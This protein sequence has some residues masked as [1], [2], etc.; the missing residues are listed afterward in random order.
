MDPSAPIPSSNVDNSTVVI[1]N[2]AAPNAFS[3]RELNS[4][5]YLSL[6][7]LYKLRA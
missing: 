6:I 2:L 1:P 5:Q 4:E 3:H 7:G